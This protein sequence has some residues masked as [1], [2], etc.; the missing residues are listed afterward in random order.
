VISVSVWFPLR[1]P[2]SVET[3]KMTAWVGIFSVIVLR[4]TLS[5]G[6]PC[7]VSGGQSTRFGYLEWRS[8]P[9]WDHAEPCLQACCTQSPVFWWT[10]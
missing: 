3:S 9:A 10:C 4:R 5:F 2:R 6:P 8:T 7:P 1:I